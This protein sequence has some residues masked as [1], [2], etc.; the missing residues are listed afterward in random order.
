VAKKGF[1]L[2]EL[3]VVIAIIAILAA[4]LFPVFAQAKLAA[5]KTSSISNVKQAT[6]AGILYEG[7][8]DDVL[9]P[10]IANGTRGDGLGSE[11]GSACFGPG[12]SAPCR[13]GY[14]IL[15]QPY[16]K[17]RSMFICPNDSAD[18]PQLGDG[19]GHGRFDTQNMFYY[20]VFG[21]FPSYG[22]NITYLNNSFMGPL[23]PDYSGKSA[24][25]L[26]S[27]ASTVLFAEAT[28]KDYTTPGRPVITNPVGYYRVLPPS[29]WN[30]SVS[31]PDAR[32]QGQLWGRFAPKSVIVSWLDGHVKYTPI[33]RLKG[34]GTTTD[35]IDRY[36][37]GLDN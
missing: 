25:S 10:A 7:D 12:A 13:F 30:T 4:I 33:G 18:D 35:E 2:I 6:L 11:F 26:S 19:M 21:S 37:N 17:N 29:T 32:S 31:Y 23:G 3:L 24:T 9:F 28:A 14:P 20:Y 5:K 8:Y 34:I 15:L 27:V 1:T 16:S 22:M 36:W